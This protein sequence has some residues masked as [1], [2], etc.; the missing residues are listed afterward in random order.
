MP[1]SK[2]FLPKEEAK[3]KVLEFV[4]HKI[5]M[6]TP[7]VA[8][9]YVRRKPG[10]DFRMNDQVQVTTGVDRIEK[11]DE[12]ERA[13]QRSL[14]LLAQIQQNAYQE[15]HQLGLDDG[16]KQA[17]D[18]ASAM[19]KDKMDQLTEVLKN[20][21]TM[22]QEILSH[23]E[24]HM[25]K[26]L[27]HM[28]SRIAMTTLENNNPSVVEVLRGAVALAQDEEN[29]RVQLHPDQIEFIEDLRRQTNREFEFLKKIRLEPDPKVKPGGCIVETNYGEIDA[30]VET[31]LA[32]LWE[33]LSDSLPKV[34]DKV[35]GS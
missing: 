11:S 32:Q 9:E 13:E 10:S 21:G 1:W 30:Q 4:P 19:I 16:R 3:S 22:K 18:E 31:R 5:D 26:L 2:N 15:G 34:K 20:L 29:V 6:G 27:Y 28:A 33:S 7:E 8:M 35:T 24:A 12:E 23:N 14:E 17:F 25:I